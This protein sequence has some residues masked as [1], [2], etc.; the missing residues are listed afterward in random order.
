VLDTTPEVSWSKGKE[1][2]SIMKLYGLDSLALKTK[3]RRKP[4][5]VAV[6][7]VDPVEPVVPVLPVV[8]VIQLPCQQMYD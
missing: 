7:P 5:V 2:V 3:G 8:P 4:V 6:V 1:N